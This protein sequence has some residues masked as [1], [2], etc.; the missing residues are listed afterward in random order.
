METTGAVTSEYFILEWAALDGYCAVFNL[1]EGMP[2]I[3][4]PARGIRMG[5]EYPDGLPFRM[6]KQ[7]PGLKIADVI[8]NAVNYFMVSKRM[9]EFL[10]RHS[11]AD[12]EFLRF[13]L[14]NHRGRVASEDCYLANVIGTQ[15]CVD[16]D[17]SDG[18]RD[19]LKPDRF[20]Y[21]RRLVLKED[22]LDSSAKLF[23]TATAP[24]LM[25]VR[26]DLKAQVEQEGITGITWYPVGSEVEI[27]L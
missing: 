7:E 26:K 9:K 12:I 15:D 27:T 10:A 13:V 8:A 19:A 5:S 20:M 22:G 11:G 24:R 14:L 2:K 25:I 6:A 4:K 16:M 1:P 18:D 21:L 3:H 23:R 17:R